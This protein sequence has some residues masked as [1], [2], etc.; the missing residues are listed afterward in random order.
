MVD[1]FTVFQLCRVYPPMHRVVTQLRPTKRNDAM[2]IADAQ[3]HLWAK[4]K[5]SAH[6]RQ[7]PCLKDEALADMD[8]ADVDRAV[9]HPVLWDP[10]SNELAVEAARAQAPVISAF[11]PVSLP[12]RDRNA[13]CGPASASSQRYAQAALAVALEVIPAGQ[14]W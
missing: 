3:I 14:S 1:R 11:L 5:S 8:A 10:D 7:T 6:H 2:M 13:R 12:L 4:G 9:V